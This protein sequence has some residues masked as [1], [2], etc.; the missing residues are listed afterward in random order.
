MGGLYEN[1][2]AHLVGGDGRS[3]FNT[4]AEYVIFRP[5]T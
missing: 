1:F 3:F 2:V 4:T 5:H